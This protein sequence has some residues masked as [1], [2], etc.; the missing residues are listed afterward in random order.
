MLLESMLLEKL[1]EKE[2]AVLY[3]LVW[4]LFCDVVNVLLS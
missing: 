4:V 3:R 2:S 1:N